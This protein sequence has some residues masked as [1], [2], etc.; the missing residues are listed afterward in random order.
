MMYALPPADIHH[1]QL[2]LPQAF[3]KFLLTPL[4]QPGKFHKKSDSPI[5]VS[6]K[7]LGYEL[8]NVQILKGDVPNFAKYTIQSQIS[9]LGL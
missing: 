6:V 9:A 8:L 7:V 1:P 5:R 3:L 2:G 4:P